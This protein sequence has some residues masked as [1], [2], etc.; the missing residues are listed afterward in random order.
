MLHTVFRRGRARLVNFLWLW[1]YS[2]KASTAGNGYCK[3]YCTPHWPSVPQLTDEADTPSHS[4]I[5][6][7]MASL[8]ISL[9]TLLYLPCACPRCTQ[10]PTTCLSNLHSSVDTFFKKAI[11]KNQPWSVVSYLISS[12]RNIRRK[13][14]TVESN[15]GPRNRQYGPRLPMYYLCRIRSHTRTKVSKSAPSRQQGICYGH[16]K[17]DSILAAW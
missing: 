9:E 7:C 12:R 14:E 17:R 13:E 6:G 11:Q 2:G 8:R 10:N 5:D 1:C 4:C 3:A 16:V 15:K